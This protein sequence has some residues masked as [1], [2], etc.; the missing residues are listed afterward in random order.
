MR[1]FIIA[2]VAAL[3]IVGSAGGVL[4]A[5]SLTGS[6]SGASDV[7]AQN[8]NGAWIG[9][10]LVQTPSG[11]TVSTVI[12]GS[13]GEK[14]GLQR[15]DVIKA[16]DGTSVSDV[17]GV[18]NALKNKKAGD[19]TTL[20]ISRNGNTQD[21]KVTLETAPAPLPRA[22][23]LFPELN[24]VPADQIFSHLMGGTFTFKDAS[25]NSH[26]ATIDLGTVSSVDT[27]AKT[28]TVALNAGGSKTYNITSGVTLRPNDLSKF[29]N[30]DKVTVLSVDGNLRAIGKGAVAG[31]LPFFG[32]G[33]HGGFG[34]G[35][36][37]RGNAGSG[38]QGS[39]ATAAR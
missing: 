35:H 3:A 25:N 29:Q 30:G 34:K 38:G 6:G 20:S 16:V 17:A 36:G 5:R 11:P 18:K 23:A 22:N 21:V 26:T 7:A 31:G 15:G 2:A 19:T 10:S 12:A 9:I 24:G 37:F 4:A 33:M 28:I 39:P 14:A 13:P 27:N 8:A 1:N 32:G